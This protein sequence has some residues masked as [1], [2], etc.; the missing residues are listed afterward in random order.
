[1]VTDVAVSDDVVI[2]APFI[3]VCTHVE[4]GN[5]H[6]KIE[7]SSPSTVTSTVTASSLGKC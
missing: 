3:P 2:D 4:C 7:S 1:M 5:I 6:V